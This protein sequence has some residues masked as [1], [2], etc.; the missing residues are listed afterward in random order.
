MT[1][2]LS[3]I[4]LR[5]GAAY[6]VPLAQLIGSFCNCVVPDGQRVR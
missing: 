1:R 6:G 3:Y 4:A 5:I 2:L